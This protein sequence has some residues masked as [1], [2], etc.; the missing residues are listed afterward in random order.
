MGDILSLN[1]NACG[2][3]KSGFI[4]H[5]FYTLVNY[6]DIENDL[7]KSFKKKL[8]QEKFVGLV[9]TPGVI[10][11]CSSCSQIDF[12]T[13]YEAQ[14]IEAVHQCGRCGSKAE[15]I[16]DPQT[17]KFCPKC[18]NATLNAECTGIWD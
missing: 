4:G 8:D 17:L 15:I 18:E 14:D 13:H 1:C 10:V 7:P 2:W 9:S 16:D 6:E 3:I 12:R 11:V 5:G